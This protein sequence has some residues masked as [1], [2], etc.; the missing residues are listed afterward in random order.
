MTLYPH[1]RGI[2]VHDGDDGIFAE[3]FLNAAHVA[4]APSDTNISSAD[5]TTPRTA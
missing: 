4:F 2:P 3:Q 1:T 5:I